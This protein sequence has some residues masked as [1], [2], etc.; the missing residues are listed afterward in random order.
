MQNAGLQ[1]AVDK[2]P[3]RDGGI[4]TEEKDKIEPSKEEKHMTLADRILELRKQKGI[5]QEALAD[6]LGVSR[7]AISKW[8]SEV[9]QS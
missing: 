9:S 8:E 3:L 6:K 4:A 1:P 5:S 7:Q 2:I